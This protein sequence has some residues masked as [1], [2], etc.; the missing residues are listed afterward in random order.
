MVNM[1]SVAPVVVTVSGSTTQKE[2]FGLKPGTL[3][4]VVIKVFRFY[5]VGCSDTRI[6]RTG[7]LRACVGLSKRDGQKIE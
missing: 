1:S 2:V 5:S 7:Q 4:T 3:Y 6:A